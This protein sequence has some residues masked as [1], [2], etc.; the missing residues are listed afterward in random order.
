M[1]VKSVK[2]DIKNGSFSRVYLFHGEEDFLRNS[3]KK[4]L[5]DAVVPPDDNMNRTLFSGKDTDVSELISLSETLPFMSERRLILVEDS[6]FFKGAVPEEFPEYLG[7]IPEETV[8]IFNESEVDKKWKMY[9]AAEKNGKVV[10]CEKQG[11]EE[12]IR[13]I[14]S[15]LGKAS[16]KIGR[17]GAELLLMR[18]GNDMYSLKNEMD[19]LISFTGDRD[20][21]TEEDIRNCTGVSLNSSIFAMI[22]DIAEGR[23]KAALEK[24]YELTLLKEAPLRILF[25]LSREF[26]ML[27]VAKDL[28]KE[29]KNDKE[30]AEVMKVPWFAVKKYVAAAKR[31]E[32]ERIVRA[33]EDCISTED[34]IKKG[35]INDRIGTEMLIISYS[36]GG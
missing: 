8:I 35:R 29:G 16:K 32:R 2:D 19:K 15:Y 30:M 5:A 24:Y 36:Q 3:F 33:I 22:D 13:W 6:G 1:L 9:K 31:F 21:V 20:S 10:L 34:D 25:L 27:L 18:T 4:S 23:Q 12:L 14:A 26:N 11:D 28:L 7:H 17:P